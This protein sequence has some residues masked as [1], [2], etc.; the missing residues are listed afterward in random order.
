MF[1]D[2]PLTLL[3]WYG[4]SG[5]FSMANYVGWVRFQE[6]LLGATV[7]RAYLSFVVILLVVYFAVAGPLFFRAEFYIKGPALAR[8]RLA[9]VHT[10][11]GVLWVLVDTPL[12]ALDLSIAY[13]HGFYVVLQGICFILRLT[14]WLSGF[15]LLWFLGMRRATRW[16]HKRCTGFPT[17]EGKKYTCDDEMLATII[18]RRAEEAAS[19]FD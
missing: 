14:S 17:P 12:L 6:D 9:H 16:I 11:V 4:G 3:Y 19:S 8:S 2:H 15:F 5:A 10:G 13:N 1:T 7:L 18:R